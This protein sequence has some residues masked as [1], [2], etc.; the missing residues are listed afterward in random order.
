MQQ[1]N[2]PV[3]KLLDDER[4]KQEAKQ[5]AQLFEWKPFT[6]ANAP[7]IKLMKLVQ[8]ALPFLSIATGACFLIDVFNG[9]PIWLTLPCALIPFMLWEFGKNYVADTTFKGLYSGTKIIGWAIALA[10]FVIGSLFCSVNGART[11]YASIDNQKDLIQQKYQILIDS[12]KAYYEGQINQQTTDKQSFVKNNQL[13]INNRIGTKFNHKLTPTL[14]AYESRLDTLRQESREALKV[15]K[16]ERKNEIQQAAQDGGFNAWVFGGIALVIDAYI[17]IAVW[18][19]IYAKYRLAL[20]MQRIKGE[21]QLLQFDTHH[22]HQLLNLAGLQLAP[23]AASGLQ[24][25]A[26]PS[27]IGF[28]EA[29]NTSKPQAK[30]LAFD[31]EASKQRSDY[32]QKYPKMCKDIVAIYEGRLACTYKSLASEYNIDE[33]T[34]HRVK[35][36]ILAI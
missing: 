2:N 19:P 11:V 16:Q 8:L 29:G 6:E 36:S 35:K 18:F 28:H 4:I 13:F 26:S 31:F 20:D 21:A 10:V 24:E 22:L 33:S 25:P 3:K 9:F 12:T 1:L 23:V 15:L 17:L 32:W 14:Q 30:Q 5:A 7:M 34:V 27:K